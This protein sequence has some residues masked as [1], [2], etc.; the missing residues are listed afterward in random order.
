MPE[1]GRTSLNAR[2]RAAGFE[3]EGAGE[4]AGRAMPRVTIASEGALETLRR[5]RDDPALGMRRLVDLTVVD[6]GGSPRF[7]VVYVLCAPDANE[8]IRVRVA[9]PEADPVLDSAVALWPAAG[10]LER[11]AFDLFG[12]RFRGHPDLRRILLPSDF[13]GAPL[14][15]DPVGP[16]ADAAASSAPGATQ[17]GEGAG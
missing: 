6:R 17:G 4:G 1:A 9:V 2:L 11:E 3:V 10:W 12:L 13:E 8:S 16:S 15:R 7:E 5:L 14:R